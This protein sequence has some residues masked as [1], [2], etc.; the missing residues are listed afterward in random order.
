MLSEENDVIS[1]PNT[2]AQGYLLDDIFTTSIN[3]TID[4]RIVQF[5]IFL[6]N[7]NKTILGV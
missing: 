2:H 4:E 6:M 1:V 3:D 7:G 5:L